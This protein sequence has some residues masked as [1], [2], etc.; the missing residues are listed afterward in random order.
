M[1]RGLAKANG[2]DQATAWVEPVDIDDSVYWL[3]SNLEQHVAD[4]LDP[5]NR[6][7]RRYRDHLL[8]LPAYTRPRVGYETVVSHLARIKRVFAEC[9]Q[10]FISGSGKTVI[11]TLDTVEAIRGMYVLQTVTQWMKALPATLF[12]LAGRPPMALDASADPVYRELTD[13]HQPLPVRTVHLGGFSWNAALAYLTAS[14]LASPGPAGASGLSED[15][16]AKVVHLTQGHPLWL[17]FAVDYLRNSG[18]PEEAEIDLADLAVQVPFR[19]KATAAGQIRYEKFK[20]RPGGALPGDR[21]LARGAQAAGGGA[22]EHQPAGLG[23]VHGRPPP[24]G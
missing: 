15:E 9:Y 18:L 2:S 16:L 13:P 22:R 6:Y 17:A 23:R 12:I 19:G 14:G 4:V 21:L 20:R 11:I 24:S 8:R 7:F 1:V 10:E 5:D 3:V